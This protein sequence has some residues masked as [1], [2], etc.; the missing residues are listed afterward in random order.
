MGAS[1][2]ARQAGWEHHNH[3]EE[4][5]NVECQ[6]KGHDSR[7]FLGHLHKLCVPLDRTKSEYGGEKWCAAAKV[8]K[9]YLG[10]GVGQ[11]ENVCG[12]QE[13]CSVQHILQVLAAQEA[14]DHIGAVQAVNAVD[15]HHPA[16]ATVVPGQGA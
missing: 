15:A 4:D 7:S 1:S 13:A 5:S 2:L 14:L 9:A 6:T 12:V 8:Q 10:E 16:L 11:S 3:D